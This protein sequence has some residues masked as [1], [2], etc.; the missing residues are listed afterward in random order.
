MTDEIKNLLA[1]RVHARDIADTAYA[2]FW[3]EAHA[4]YLMD[5]AHDDF[6]RLAEAM[7]YRVEKIEAQAEVAA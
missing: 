5:K 7:G 1:I 4:K 6:L 2:A 3:S